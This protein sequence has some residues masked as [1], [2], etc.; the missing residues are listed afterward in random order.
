VHK[1]TRDGNIQKLERNVDDGAPPP[2]V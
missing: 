1:R 2:A